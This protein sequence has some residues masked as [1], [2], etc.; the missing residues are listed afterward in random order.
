VF[1]V[2]T[3]ERASEPGVIFGSK[4]VGEPPLMLA[5]SVRE[6]IRDAV[7]AFGAGGVVTL[8][9]PATP[10]RIFWAVKRAKEQARRVAAAP[11]SAGGASIS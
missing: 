11:V 10:E 9:S 6:A 5:I 4:A 1:N 8:D 3:L 2:S 7:A